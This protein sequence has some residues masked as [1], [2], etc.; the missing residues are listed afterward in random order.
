MHCFITGQCS[1]D[2]VA[3]I[4][5]HFGDDIDERKLTRQ[6]P[7]LEDIC[8][9]TEIKTVHDV[10]S[11]LN[12]DTTRTTCALL[13]QVAI[14]IRLLLVL[15]SSSCSAERSFSTLRRLKTYLRSNMT[16]KRL[17]AVAVLNIH[18]DCTDA[19]DLNAVLREFVTANDT[20]RSL[21]GAVQA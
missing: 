15:P 9:G 5:K 10:I 6:L 4:S 8:K 14:L 12:R 2:D 21:F 3:T 13:D 19:L 1:T 16:A 11:V 7:L 18:K 17:N 20:R